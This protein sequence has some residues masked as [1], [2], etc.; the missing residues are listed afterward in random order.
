MTAN[1]MLWTRRAA[2]IQRISF[3]SCRAVR[4]TSQ[5]RVKLIA[6][7]RQ[8]SKKPWRAYSA[9]VKLSGSVRVKAPNRYRPCTKKN[10]R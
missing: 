4:V 3:C 6:M 7:T 10:T 5:K 2:A 8:S 9:T 1:S